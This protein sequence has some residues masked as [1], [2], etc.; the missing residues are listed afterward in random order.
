MASEKE[1]DMYKEGK[2]LLNWDVGLRWVRG[3]NVEK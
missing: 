2:T 3:V 1:R